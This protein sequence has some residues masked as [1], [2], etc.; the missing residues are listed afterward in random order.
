MIAPRVRPAEQHAHLRGNRNACRLSEHQ[1][2][3]RQVPVVDNQLLHTASLLR[4]RASTR[5]SDAAGTAP[6]TLR[7]SAVASWRPSAPKPRLSQELAPTPNSPHEFMNWLQPRQPDLGFS[8]SAF[9]RS[10][11]GLL[12]DLL[13]VRGVATPRVLPASSRWYRSRRA[14]RVRRTS[15]RRGWEAGRP[16]PFRSL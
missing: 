13:L 16:R 8:S 12:G 14:A 1:H 6:R 7:Q 3:Y 11:E 2:E 4:R 10:R 9:G 15:Q 5:A